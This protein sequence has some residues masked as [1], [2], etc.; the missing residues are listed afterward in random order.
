MTAASVYQMM[1]GTIVIITALMAVIFLKAKQYRHHWLALLVLFIG[2]FLVGLSSLL[3]PDT[4]HSGESTGALGIIL[5]IIAM[6]FAGTLFIV[7]EKLLGDY[8]LDPLKVVGLEGMWGLLYYLI[9]LPIMQ[10]INCDVPN[11]CSNGKI[12]DT[13]FA[14]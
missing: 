7:E 6:L 4:P 9:L 1:R 12:E 13:V 11:L 5:I 3:F 14:F 10:H 8:Y 2:V